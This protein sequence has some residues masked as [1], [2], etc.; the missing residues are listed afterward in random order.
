MHATLAADILLAGIGHRH[1]PDSGDGHVDAGQCLQD[2][3]E[4]DWIAAID[5]RYGV[6]T[7]ASGS[8]G[9]RSSNPTTRKRKAVDID[10]QDIPIL[11]IP[12][13]PA[14]PMVVDDP[15]MPMT[16]TIDPKTK[17]VIAEFQDGRK[18]ALGNLV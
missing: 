15:D 10:E 9:S 11:R 2:D 4:T 14:A 17:R 6:N 18:R 13:E 5:A 7:D 8:S 16:T 1:R 3:V 12:S